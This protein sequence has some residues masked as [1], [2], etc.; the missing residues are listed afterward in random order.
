MSGPPPLPINYSNRPLPLPR[1][2][3]GWRFFLLA[4]IAG[5]LI[6]GVT[7][8]GGWKAINEGNLGFLIL[9]VPFIKIAVATIMVCFPKY[10]AAGIGLFASI[11]VGFG[12]FFTVCASNLNFH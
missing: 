2:P 3:F 5:T 4:F 8:A 1:R 12:I 9:L 7:W 6:S 10:R 11:P